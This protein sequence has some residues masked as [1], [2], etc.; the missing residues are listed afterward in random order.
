[1]RWGIIYENLQTE[2]PKWERSGDTGALPFFGAPKG[3][4]THH[5]LRGRWYPALRDRALFTKRPPDAS[6]EGADDTAE[7]A[8]SVQLAVRHPAAFCGAAKLLFPFWQQPA[9]CIPAGGRGTRD[10]GEKRWRFTI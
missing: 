4:L 3:A 10:G 1:M 8:S 7:A 6:P 5:P 9:N 2:Q